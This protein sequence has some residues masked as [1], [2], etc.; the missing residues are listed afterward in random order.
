M[1][2]RSV[3]AALVISGMSLIS[4]QS[5]FGSEVSEEEQL[6]NLVMMSPDPQS[7]FDSLS[8]SEKATFIR[9][10]DP[11]NVVQDVSRPITTYSASGGECHQAGHHQDWNSRWGFTVATSWMDIEWCTNGGQVTSIEITNQGGE[12][13]TPGY[14]YEG[15]LNSGAR[16]DG[17][18]GR[19][20]SEIGLKLFDG[21]PVVQQLP[22]LT[23]CI[24][25]T[26]YGDGHSDAMADVSAG[27]G[28]RDI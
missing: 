9:A 2:I 17:S 7:V 14:S 18:V 4:V 12:T 26:G 22:G 1:K 16:S 11:V 6:A 27:N 25:L 28:C 10:M 19:A 13:K 24:K 21:V 3:L 20:Y 8:L 5:A 23:P 15:V